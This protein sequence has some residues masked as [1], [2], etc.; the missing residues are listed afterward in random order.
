MSDSHGHILAV[1]SKQMS[2]KRF[3][4]SPFHR[5]L[6]KYA[7]SPA[8]DISPTF[9][10]YSPE[11][12][13][14]STLLTVCVDQE[15]LTPH[16]LPPL[17]PP[18]PPSLPHSFS[19][20]FSLARSLSLSAGS[21]GSMRGVQRSIYPR[22]SASTLLRTPAPRSPRPCNASRSRERE[23]INDNLLVRIHFIVEMIWW[24]GLAPW[25]FEFPFPGSLISP[26]L[27]G[28]W[29]LVCRAT[30]H[31]VHSLSRGLP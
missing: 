18:P 14:W 7:A 20:S 2:L 4:L 1:A 11:D 24:T 29:D 25:E 26:F 3:E 10:I 13:H 5:L 19:L 23:F 30:A 12:S 6:R 28:V 31:K 8:L 15:T 17:S 9:S 22:P 27:G 16:P 21:F